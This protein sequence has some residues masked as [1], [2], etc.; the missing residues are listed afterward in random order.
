MLDSR[1]IYGVLAQAAHDRRTITYGDI[2]ARFG[3][4]ANVAN[5]ARLAKVLERIGEENV[6]KD[7]PIMAA[8]VIRRSDAL[9]GPSFFRLL[10]SHHGYAG[11]TTGPDARA[12]HQS[13]LDR[14]WAYWTGRD[15]GANGAPG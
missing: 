2:L 5:V 12:A 15:V 6:R 1:R 4:G 3:M 14:V 7:E 11:S 13:E 10:E 9:P 8:L